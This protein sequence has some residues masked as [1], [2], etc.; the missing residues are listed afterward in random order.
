MNKWRR[1]LGSCGTRAGFPD[2]M[3][4]KIVFNSLPFFCFVLLQSPSS[5]H[6]QHTS[7]QG[8][9]SVVHFPRTLSSGS[10]SGTAPSGVT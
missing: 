6:G 5:A 1:S 4:Q 3:C 7:S 9:Q 8:F 2:K 10:T